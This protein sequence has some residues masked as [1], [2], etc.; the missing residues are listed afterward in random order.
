MGHNG[1][2]QLWCM[3]PTSFDIV[4]G[5]WNIPPTRIPNVENNNSSGI[6]ERGIGLRVRQV[7]LKWIRITV[8]LLRLTPLVQ[9]R[10]PEQ[11]RSIPWYGQ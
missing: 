2:D 5:L 1:S 8:L 10:P 7:M 4:G 9:S 11:A 3:G 6:K